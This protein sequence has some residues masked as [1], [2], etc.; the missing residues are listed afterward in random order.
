MQK[1]EII[2]IIDI[3]SS[4]IRLLI[5]QSRPSSE[6]DLVDSAERSLALGRDVFRN[7]SIDRKTINRAV[8]ILKDFMELMAPY[9]IDRIVAIGTSALRE[10]ENR[11]VFINRVLLQTGIEV[12]VID[13]VEANQL[14]WLAVR[15]PLE[16]V[17][18]DFKHYKSMIIEVGAGN[19]ELMIL[20]KGNIMASYALPIGALRYLQRIDSKVDGSVE[21]TFRHHASRNIRGISHELDL[22]K[23]SKLLAIGSDARLVASRLGKSLSPQMD[24]IPLAAFREFIKE[25]ETYNSDELVEHLNLPWN[26]AELLYPSLI[27]LNEFVES[28]RA[29]EIFVHSGNIRQGLLVNYATGH[30]ALR[31]IFSTQVIESSRG[32]A[33]HYRAN[34]KHAEFVRK[35]AIVLYNKLNTELDLKDRLLLESA[36]LLHDI[37]T[38]ISAENHHKHSQYIIQNSDIFGLSVADKEI[39]GHIVRYHRRSQPRNSHTSYMKLDRRSRIIVQKL[40]AL[41]RIADAL[42][43]SHT[44]SV[45]ISDLKAGNKKLTIFTA[46]AGDISMEKL[47]LAEKSDF[48]ENLF[49]LKILLRN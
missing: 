25:I 40:A 17:C 19:T 11:E 20:R 47:S 37:G 8:A 5:A 49:G 3:G 22:S 31:E 38:Y 10:S 41:L 24:V 2:A 42:D 39:V 32:I 28:T 23:I 30:S 27:I 4:A 18:A 43:R 21:E 16:A 33:K 45:V 12:A 7:G 26:E 48:F 44:Q 36:A 15:E 46:Y 35:Q 34:M 29:D 9:G 6:W 1:Q 14:T 13:G